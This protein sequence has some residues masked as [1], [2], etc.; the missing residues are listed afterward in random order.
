M[1]VH[2]QQGIDNDD[3]LISGPV[4]P[5]PDD[6]DSVGFFTR[7]CH[8]L[9]PTTLEVWAMKGQQ[10]ADTSARLLSLE[11]FDTSYSRRSV[12]LDAFDGDTVYVGF[13]NVSTNDWNGLCLDDIWFSRVHVPGTCEPQSSLATQP[14]LA[15]APNPAKGRFITIRYNIATGTRG[16]L[17]L[18]DV[19]GRMVRSFALGPSGITRIDLRG[20]AQGI[21]MVTLDAAGLSVA[22]KLI[23]TAPK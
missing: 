17:T 21:Y 2:E 22:R 4:Y 12:S 13:G 20:F 14:E 1:S 23:L 15:F 3:R 10:V 6:P 18:H 8:L 11:L 7:G 9:V 19:L 16:R 5:K